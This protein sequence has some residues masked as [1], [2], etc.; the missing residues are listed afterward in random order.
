MVKGLKMHM[1]RENPI[2]DIGIAIIAVIVITYLVIELL[3]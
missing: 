2:L 1:N 3:I